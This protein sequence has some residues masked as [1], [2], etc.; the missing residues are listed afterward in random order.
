[1]RELTSDDFLVCCGDSPVRKV[2]ETTSA[3]YHLTGVIIPVK[4]SVY[5]E[6]DK[7]GKRLCPVATNS[8]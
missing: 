4:E 3:R 2:T 6:C 5:Y 7:C 1:M 8:V